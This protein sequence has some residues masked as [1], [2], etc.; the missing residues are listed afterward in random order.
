MIPLRVHEY[1][2]L[3]ASAAPF[4]RGDPYLFT[5]P[6]GRYCTAPKLVIRTVVFFS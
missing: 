6:T 1:A 2:L 5:L 4:A 3:H